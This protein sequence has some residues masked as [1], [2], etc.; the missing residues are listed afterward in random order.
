MRK[1]L[2]LI[3]VLALAGTAAWLYFGGVERVTEARVRTALTEKGVP[4]RL[5]ECMAGR[6]TDQLTIAQLRSLERL[7]PLEG[8]PGIP[9]AP[10]DV[11]ERMRRLRAHIA[12]N[13]S[14]ER[15]SRELGVDVFLGRARFTDE[16]SVEVGGETLR[17]KTEYFSRES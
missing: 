16:D 12:P 1:A 13:D 4:P 15:F 2:I 11:M 10:G 9:L 5:A 3:I 17:F 14:A 8:E 6:M 7:A